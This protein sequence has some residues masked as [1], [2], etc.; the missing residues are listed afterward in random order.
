MYAPI[1][2]DETYLLY[3]P[4]DPLLYISVVFSLLP[5]GL[6][7]FY[8][9]WFVTSRELEPCFLAFGQVCNNVFNYGLKRVFRHQRPSALYEFVNYPELKND[10][11]MP[12]AHSQFM[13][14]FA[15]FVVMRMVFQRRMKTWEKIVYGAAL[16]GAAAMTAFS[17]VY[18]M[19]HEADQVIVGV[20]AGSAVGILYFMLV[21]FLRDIGL[22]EWGL[23]LPF[24]KALY[25]KDSYDCAL[26]YKQEYEMYIERKK[27]KQKSD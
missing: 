12:S 26:S 4:K 1:P 5:I 25:I 11:G 13:G 27:G 9:S 16:Y 20:L 19:Y 6:L 24:V 7:I 15:T 3:D 23:N 2:F 22:I 10:Y 21:S 17:R 8:F 14:Y 18:L